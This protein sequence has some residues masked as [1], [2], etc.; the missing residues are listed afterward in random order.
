MSPHIDY[1]LRLA[2]TSL[3]LGQRLAEWCGHGPVLEED[4]ALTNVALDCIGQARLLLSHAGAVEGQGRDED[5]LAF[6][7][8]DGRYRNLTIVELPNG[9]F[10]AT[11][12]RNLLV[13]AWQAQVWASLA[14]STDRALAGIAEKS[15]K[16]TRY[17]VTHAADWTIRLGDGTD[18]SHGRMQAALDRL[19]PYT[20]EFFVVD[21]VD[22]AVAA[23]GIAPLCSTL[24]SAWLATVVPVLEEATLGV[25]GRSPF[26]SRGKAGVHTEHLGPLLA[27]MQH[28]QRAYPGGQ[29]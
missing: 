16:E 21:A 8:D 9:D 4:L 7:R 28:L 23:A 24:E 15:A 25:P 2:D 29:W 3:I 22:Q 1:L 18:E 20:A 6:L 12:V 13:N 26:R 11:V 17:H 27:G 10:G 5:Q 14:D 19:W